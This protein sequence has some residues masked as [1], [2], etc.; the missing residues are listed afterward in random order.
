MS[1]RNSRRPQNLKASALFL[2]VLAAL[3]L[4]AHAI[5]PA[6]PM[7]VRVP[8]HAFD[9]LLEGEPA[10]SLD[11]RFDGHEAGLRLV[12]FDGAID[13]AWLK[14][15]ELSGLKVLQYYPHNAYLVWGDSNA[16]ATAQ[17]RGHVRW[18]GNFHPAYKVSAALAARTGR[19]RN[20]D[21]FIY[22]DGH[23]QQTLDALAALGGTV[24]QTYP[25]QADRTFFVAVVEMSARSLAAAAELGTVV[26]M[27]YADPKPVLDDEMSDQIQAG[28][29]SQAGVPFTGYQSFLG[30]LGFDGTGVRWAVTDDG[31]DYGHPDLNTHIVDGYSFP[32]CTPAQPG[33]DCPGSGHG[34]HVAGII[35]ATAAG[36]FADANGFKY[37]LG[38]APGYGIV[39]L[40]AIAG[41]SWPPVGGWQESSKQAVVRGA[42]GTNNSWT[43]GEGTNHGYQASERTHDLIVRDGNFDTTAIEPFIEVFSAGNS[44]PGA[45]TLTAPKEAKNLIVVA[46]TNNYRTG[47]IN[48]VASFSSRGPSVDGR[49]V[50]TVAAPGAQIAST[51]S[52]NSPGSCGT[53]IAGTSNLYSFCSGTS[54]ASPHVSG[55][56]VL[57][58][59]W[60]RGFN[61]GANPSPA[62]A[63]ALLVNSAVPLGTIP[64]MVEG[65]GRVNVTDLIAPAVGTAY[66]DQ[67]EILANSGANWTRSFGVLDSSK[68]LKVTLAWSDAPGAPGANPALVNN[69]DLSVVANGN[70]YLGNA[71]SGGWS[72][73]GGSADAL[74]NLENVYVQN[75]G[76][77]GVTVT[78]NATNIAGDGVPGNADTTDQD[79][80][81]ICYNCAEFPDY[82]VLSTP[83][84]QGICA[85]A[86]ANYTINVDSILGY[87]DPVTLSVGGNPA[88][89]TSA[90]SVNPVIPVGS[91]VLTIGNTAAAT[92]GSYTLA[93]TA[94]STSGNKSLNL[95]LNVYN[96]TPGSSTLSNP[97]D[98]A[99][100][101]PPQPSFSWSAASQAATYSIQVASDVGF[102]TI[103]ASA[104]GVS[105]TSWNSNVTLNT[106]STYY[107]R[108]WADNMCGTGTQS[109]VNS[110]NTQAAPGDCGIGSTPNA[111]LST[112]FESGLS[113]WSQGS[114]GSGTN[115]WAISSSAPHAGAAHLHA[116]DTAS[117][118]DQRMVSP[119][120]ALP[121]GQNPV[122]LKFWHRPDNESSSSGCYD[123]G[124]LEV[125]NNGGT[126]WTQVPAADILVGGYTGAIAAGFS[127]PL[128]GLQAWCG[129]TSYQQTIVDVSGYA[130][131]NV[132]FRY[133]LGTDSSVGDVGWDVDDVSVQSCNVTTDEIFQDGF[134]L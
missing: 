121:S 127:N 27:G 65:W 125:S 122:T 90:F 89:T 35:G 58:S 100:N 44:G 106:S 11:Q 101:V 68:P 81:V 29:Y 39:T 57:A 98:G 63:K 78:V 41:N 112:D 54:M 25:A 55:A 105:G 97:A 131:Q 16:L 2:A 47:A 17:A 67:T 110:F 32:G 43:T 96:A 49:I 34:T 85:P 31:V 108:V 77:G 9:P 124:I 74:N 42:V 132:Q 119:S 120:I 3:P 134:E 37:G 40:N 93:M 69:L 23:L 79:F 86:D 36:G 61:A 38:V 72:T 14:G 102:N 5:D 64:N 94:S 92:P 21:V 60:W 7:Q 91:S 19:I 53:A 111:L 117:A 1:R 13:D 33:G 83:A 52:N 130:G 113:G 62:M 8:N 6:S 114:G 104:S 82:G 26:W 129:V 133:R 80:A 88:G 28:N 22:N 128:A 118:T 30:T 45:N 4:A 126:S 75:P 70:T 18:S 107:W 71:F 73:T 15:L 123:G 20:V 59:Q 109:Q 51:R 84:T 116:N 24:I 46:A 115:T 95:G 50:P 10:L 99:S 12:Q 56:L 76:S 103:V 66:F 48:S 87:S